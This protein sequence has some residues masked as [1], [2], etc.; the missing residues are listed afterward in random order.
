MVELVELSFLHHAE[1]CLKH[2]FCAK[3]AKK[4]DTLGKVGAA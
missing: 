4:Y 2:Y 1:E 3:S